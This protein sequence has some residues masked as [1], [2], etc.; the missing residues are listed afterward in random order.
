VPGVGFLFTGSERVSSSFIQAINVAD[1]YCW[2]DRQCT[3]KLQ[4]VI[5]RDRN[6]SIQLVDSVTGTYFAS[7]YSPMA[8]T[9]KELVI[10]I[11]NIS[12]I[13]DTS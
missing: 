13:G 5:G 3:S 1:H 8:E 4:K 11:E 2:F 7:L 6:G 12:M 9:A 10:H